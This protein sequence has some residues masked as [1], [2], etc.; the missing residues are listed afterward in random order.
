M[1]PWIAGVLRKAHC[2][3]QWRNQWPVPKILACPPRGGLQEKRP[4]LPQGCTF[5]T[6]S[7][8]SGHSLHVE[9]RHLLGKETPP[10]LD[11]ACQCPWSWELHSELPCSAHLVEAGRGGTGKIHTDVEWTFMSCRDTLETCLK[12][13]VKT[14]GQLSSPILGFWGYCYA[15][16]CF[17]HCQS[18]FSAE[19]AARPGWFLS[20]APALVLIASRPKQNEKAHTVARASGWWN[21]SDKPCAIRDGGRLAS[22][23]SILQPAK[24]SAVARAGQQM[25]SLPPISRPAPNPLEALAAERHQ[26]AALMSCRWPCGRCASA[27]RPAQGLL[28]GSVHS[29]PAT[30]VWSARDAGH[31]TPAEMR[32]QLPLPRGR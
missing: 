9:L 25:D 32:Q 18:A 23:G 6:L 4:H 19:A 26:A 20:P 14:S 15:P 16:I 7:A 3:G 24:Q 28:S 27:S 22:A 21:G 31:W 29:G 17:E 30:L 11:Q 5:K 10:E 12:M 2:R 8:Q 13:S 1:H